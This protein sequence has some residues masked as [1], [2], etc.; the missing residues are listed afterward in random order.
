MDFF[1]CSFKAKDIMAWTLNCVILVIETKEI[2][3]IRSYCV[4]YLA[5]QMPMVSL[6]SN[7]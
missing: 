6:M 5:V 7:E 2:I 1:K 4:D 3:S